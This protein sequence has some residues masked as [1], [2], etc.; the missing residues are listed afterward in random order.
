VAVWWSTKYALRLNAFAAAVLLQ[1][2]LLETTDI[3][4]CR[5]SDLT[6]RFCFG[7]MDSVQVRG[8]T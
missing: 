1:R 6:L 7:L 2:G 5:R 8:S 4:P 3:E